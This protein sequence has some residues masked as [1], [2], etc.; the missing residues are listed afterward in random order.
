MYKTSLLAFFCDRMGT[1]RFQGDFMKFDLFEKSKEYIIVVAH[2]G[3]CAE[4]IPCN[5][6]T[7]Y[8]IAL[9]QG[10]DTI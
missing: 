9:L 4:N 10:A 1:E 7:A 2:R 3:A 8:E 5:T 6:P